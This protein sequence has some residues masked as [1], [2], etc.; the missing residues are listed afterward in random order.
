MKDIAF[1]SARNYDYGGYQSASASAVSRFFDKKAGS[2][3]SLNEQLAE[4][5]HKQ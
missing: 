3:V 2:G 5:L 4:E 1:K